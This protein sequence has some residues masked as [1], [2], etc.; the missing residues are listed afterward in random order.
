MIDTMVT[1]VSV[2][3]SKGFS[4]TDLYFYC[5]LKKLYQFDKLTLEQ[6]EK[7]LSIASKLND[8]YI[9][10]F[11]GKN[12][13]KIVEFINLHLE[14]IFIL[15]DKKVNEDVINCIFREHIDTEEKGGL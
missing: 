10:E 3:R 7:I 13:H 8:I 2:L 4:H 1:A 12:P 6:K 9:N 11:E 14:I 15:L 5:E